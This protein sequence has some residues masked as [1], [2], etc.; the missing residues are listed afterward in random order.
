MA[1]TR[2][3]EA[4]SSNWRRVACLVTL[5][6]TFPRVLQGPTRHLRFGL[7]ILQIKQ[8][9]A[10]IDLEFPETRVHLATKREYAPRDAFVGVKG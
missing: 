10:A 1:T 7:G 2:E 6:F 9:V 4:D 3:H 8:S 5:L